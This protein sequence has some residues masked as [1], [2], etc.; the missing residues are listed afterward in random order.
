MKKALLLLLLI[1][2]FV[3]V[4]CKEE[5][6]TITLVLE[7]SSI[8][9]TFQIT[10][11]K[12]VETKDVMGAVHNKVY[13]GYGLY[14]YILFYDEDM[15]ESY[16][17]EKVKTDKTLYF[18]KLKPEFDEKKIVQLYEQID[19]YL[20]MD[21]SFEDFN[22]YFTDSINEYK[23]ITTIRDW[24]EIR[25]E[26]E[27][28]IA[29][30]TFFTNTDEKVVIKIP[31]I[32]TAILTFDMYSGGCELFEEMV[33]AEKGKDYVISENEFIYGSKWI[34]MD[35]LEVYD[36]VITNVNKTNTLYI[37]G[38]NGPWFGLTNSYISRINNFAFSIG[39]TIYKDEL[40]AYSYKVLEDETLVIEKDG[41]TYSFAKSYQFEEYYYL[42]SIES[43]NYLFGESLEDDKNILSI[44][45]NSIDGVYDNNQVEVILKEKGYLI[46][47]DENTI[48]G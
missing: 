28:E 45:F 16:N 17:G 8:A 22:A 7:E 6:V 1:L 34:D 24:L 33:L 12:S 23:Y 31:L 26:N 35:T 4:G 40:M 20:N 43:D 18:K 15:M 38:K 29:R 37:Y 25:I 48:Y 11:G 19:Y 3:L 42:K 5:K 44:L 27:I 9:P 2:S 14:N 47:S 41:L 21:L 13:G 36:N 30:L 32:N 10:K 39:S 46:I